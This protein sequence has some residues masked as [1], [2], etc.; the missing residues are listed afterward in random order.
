MD[1]QDW[2]ETPATPTSKGSSSST[3]SSPVSD[4][5]SS[6]SLTCTETTTDADCA[7][8]DSLSD[9][10]LFARVILLLSYIHSAQGSAGL[11][12]FLTYGLLSLI[13]MLVVTV[14]SKVHS[15]ACSCQPL[16][17]RACAFAA[18]LATG[19]D[20]MAI[21]SGAAAVVLPNVNAMA[22]SY[23]AANR[24]QPTIHVG[25]GVI[26]TFFLGDCAW[27]AVTG[28]Q[29]LLQLGRSVITCAATEG[30]HVSFAAIQAVS[31]AYAAMVLL[32][33]ALAILLIKVCSA[34]STTA[35][36]DCLFEQLRPSGHSQ[37]LLQP[38]LL[39]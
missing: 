25:F 32:F 14:A 9:I 36:F 35:G 7:A 2:K 19:L 8:V 11:A 39:H 33:S 10:P 6:I 16:W 22:W 5:A 29:H 21:W 34:A 23:M 26:C 28:I 31:W 17:D 1:M 38:I 20:L 3:N 4:K 24:N 15:L 13:T 30:F 12:A 18:T 27:S 37:S